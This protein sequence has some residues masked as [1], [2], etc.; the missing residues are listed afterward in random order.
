VNYHYIRF[1]YLA[2][3]IVYFRNLG[4]TMYAELLPERCVTYFFSRK[5]VELGYCVSA[6]NGC[7]VWNEPRI[8]DQSYIDQYEF[9]NIEDY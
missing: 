9:T 1:Y 4:A 2:E 8:W 5:G 3:A 6:T 7:I